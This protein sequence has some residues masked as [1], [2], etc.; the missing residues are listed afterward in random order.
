MAKNKKRLFLGSKVLAL[1]GEVLIGSEVGFL[2]EKKNMSGTV[3]QS[4]Y[5][6]R[7]DRH[8]PTDHEKAQEWQRDQLLATQITEEFRPVIAKRAAFLVAVIC[9]AIG[10]FAGNLQESD[11]KSKAKGLSDLAGAALIDYMNKQK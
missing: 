4:F 1:H 3:A 8:L 5:Y 6:L 2:G 7:T 11:E 10:F 9:I